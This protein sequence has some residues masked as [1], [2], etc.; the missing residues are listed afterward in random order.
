MLANPIGGRLI[1]FQVAQTIVKHPL[2]QPKQAQSADRLDLMN[3][4]NP[5][6]ANTAAELAHNHITCDLFVFTQGLG[7]RAQQYKNLA[8][9]S[10]LARRSSGNLFYYPEYSV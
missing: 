6:F 3:A 10:D 1:F 9:L 4:T 8:T 5:Y 2:L 7:A